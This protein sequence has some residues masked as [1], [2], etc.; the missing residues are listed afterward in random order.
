MQ[1][2]TRGWQ[3]KGEDVVMLEGTVRVRVF[4]ECSILSVDAVDR[5]GAFFEDS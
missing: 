4:A 1:R 3:R 2:E 5:G